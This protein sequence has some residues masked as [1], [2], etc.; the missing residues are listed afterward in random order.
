M[1]KYIGVKRIQ[2]KLMTR[3]AYNGFK[4]WTIPA[5]ENPDD[6]GYVVKY[7]DDY[8]S[9][10]PKDVFEKAYRK[11]GSDQNTIMQDDVDSF[12]KNVDYT[13]LGDKTTV[14]K[15]TLANGFILVE[16]SSCVDAKNFDMQVGTEICIEKIKDKVWFLLGFLLQCANGMNKGEN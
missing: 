12:I 7:S 9:W 1:D 15:A 4:G 8:V 11:F 6:D 14:V 5:D 10:S 2:A 16:S 13:Q 3:G